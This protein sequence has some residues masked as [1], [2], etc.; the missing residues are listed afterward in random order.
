[1]GPVLNCFI[2]ACE[3]NDV[4]YHIE[5]HKVDSDPDATFTPPA[6]FANGMVDGALVAG[7]CHKDFLDWLEHQNTRPWVGIGESTPYHV[8]DDTRQSVYLSVQHLAAIGHRRLA[9]LHGDLSFRIN[10]DALLGFEQAI[11]DFNLQCDSKWIQYVPSL[12]RRDGLEKAAAWS[13]QYLNEPNRPTAVI[14]TGMGLARAVVTV[15]LQL[16]MSIPQDLSV[17]GRG[18]EAQSERSYPC[19]AYIQPNY[20]QI[21]N[22]ALLMLDQL[23]AGRKVDPAKI[24]VPA[25]LTWHDTVAPMPTD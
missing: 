4:Q 20:K 19:L 8:S 21:V 25:N 10:N 23:L 16:G 11:G 15:A 17:M 13:H 1:M 12:P 7:Y 22:Q 6:Y 14:C 2:Q 9:L 3:R 24:L 18:T 5:F